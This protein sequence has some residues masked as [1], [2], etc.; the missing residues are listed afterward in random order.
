VAVIDVVASVSGAPD[1]ATVV[2][3]AQ[4]NA[5]QK[6]FATVCEL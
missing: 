6:G 3:L 1:E 4:N 2:A 5:D